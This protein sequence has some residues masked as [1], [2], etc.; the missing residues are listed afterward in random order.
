MAM[1]RINVDWPLVLIALAL[2]L[3][4]IATVYSAGQTD[5]VTYVA[6]AWRAQIVWFVLSLG[7]AYAISRASVRLLEWLTVPLYWFSILLLLIVLVPGFG[8]GAGT[9]AS[10]MLSDLATELDQFAASGACP[11]DFSLLLARREG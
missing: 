10:V 4:G 3:F 7:A 2:S 9:A 11:D 5:A 6:R 8:S 1:R